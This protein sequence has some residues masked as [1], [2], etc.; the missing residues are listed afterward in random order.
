ME[1][2]LYDREA[3]TVNSA[4]ICGGKLQQLLAEISVR[5]SLFD[6]GAYLFCDLVLQILRG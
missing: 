3:N 5:G 6:R 1:I 4:D 2:I